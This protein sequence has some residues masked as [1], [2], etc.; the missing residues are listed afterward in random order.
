MLDNYKIDYII[1]IVKLN[2]AKW[3][4]LLRKYFTKGRV[5]KSGKRGKGK[6]GIS[7]NNKILSFISGSLHPA[8]WLTFGD[9][10]Y[11]RF[12]CCNVCRRLYRNRHARQY[13]P[14]YRK[15]C[16]RSFRGGIGEYSIKGL[17]QV[18]ILSPVSV[19]FLTLWMKMPININNSSTHDYGRVCS[20]VCFR[21]GIFFVF[22]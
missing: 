21:H 17:I 3:V 9:T 2:Y 7:S 15:I 20:R 6:A 19:F 10:R 22:K 5:F 12:P 14:C 16:R 18:Q 1:G 4:F 8:S 13:Q 11:N